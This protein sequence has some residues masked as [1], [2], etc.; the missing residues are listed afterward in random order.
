MSISKYLQSTSGII[1]I[2]DLGAQLSDISIVGVAETTVESALEYLYQ[3]SGT[4]ATSN[5]VHKSGNETLNGTK[6]YTSPIIR[7]DSLDSNGSDL[8]KLNDDN[9]KGYVSQSAYYDSSDIVNRLE[10]YNDTSDK[11][12]YLEI[13]NGDSGS[14]YAQIGGDGNN[15]SHNSQ[16]NAINTTVVP[17]MGW[18]NDPTKSLNV[19]HRTGDETIGGIKIFNSTSTKFI[20]SSVTNG[21]LEVSSTSGNDVALK[22]YNTSNLNDNTI[23]FTSNGKITINTPSVS[24]PTDKDIVNVEWVTGN[25]VTGNNLAHLN[26]A[27]TITGNWTFT[28][29]NQVFNGVA[30]S[31]RW[32]DLAEIYETDKEYP[33]GT[34]VQFG[35]E[36]EMTASKS[37]V[38]GVISENPAFLMNNGSD[39]QP[40]AMIGRVKVRVIGKVDKFNYIKISEIDGV[41]RASEVKD[42]YVI[43]R[44]LESSD[45]E[46][47]KLVLCSVR[48]NL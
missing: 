12:G 19:V 28:N 34:L 23:T 4:G 9:G 31:A 6:T 27:E 5:I 48:F 3:Q 17:T 39:G 14:F 11:Y 42:D 20:N 41:A 33:I 13:R 46:N 47:E 25:N 24:S 21:G 37:E 22:H 2:R 36:K 32:A 18:V 15:L 40:V 45:D 8:I 38:C 7:T 43:G 26:Y 16:T 44:A 30:T 1:D 10:T 29:P 35:G